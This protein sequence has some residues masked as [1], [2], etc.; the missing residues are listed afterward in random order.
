MLF[1]RR[2]ARSSVLAGATLVGGMTVPFFAEVGPAATG[3]MPVLRAV[4]LES[5]ANPTEAG[6]NRKTE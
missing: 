1:S 2:V 3:T 4:G 5:L 6:E